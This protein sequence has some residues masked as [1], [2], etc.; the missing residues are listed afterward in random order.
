MR[1]QAERSL[2]VS[3]KCNE[4]NQSSLLIPLVKL[5]QRFFPGSIGCDAFV[6]DRQANPRS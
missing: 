1:D 5:T 3:F 4:R 2:T 6:V